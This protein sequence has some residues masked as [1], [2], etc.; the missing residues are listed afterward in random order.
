MTASVGGTPR[1]EAVTGSG[2][3]RPAAVDGG[4]DAIDA[5]DGVVVA[6]AIVPTGGGGGG[7]GA[8]PTTTAPGPSAG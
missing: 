7:G 4:V 5:G 6:A 2:V 1:A 3:R 8:G